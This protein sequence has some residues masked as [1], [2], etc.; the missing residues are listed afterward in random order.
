MKISRKNPKTQRP[1][2]STKGRIMGRRNTGVH[3]TGLW[4][5]MENKGALGIFIYIYIYIFEIYP[6][7]R[8]LRCLSRIMAGMPE[9]RNI[10]VRHVQFIWDHLG[11]VE[12]GDIFAADGIA[13]FPAHPSS[14]DRRIPIATELIPGWY[15]DLVGGWATPLKNIRQLGWLFLLY[16]NI[17]NV[18]NHQPE[19]HSAATSVSV[20]YLRFYGQTLT[21][22]GCFSLW[23][24]NANG[25]QQSGW[26]FAK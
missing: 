6:T 9:I 10:L 3:N 19:I 22:D 1:V 4:P 18:P 25:C 20:G 21:A 5:K 16:G 23:N 15:L 11:S 8:K 2:F 13:M 24:T 12:T 26:C 7:A 14:T 17:E